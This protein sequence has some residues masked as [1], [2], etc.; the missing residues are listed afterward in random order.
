M[1]EFHTG[2]SSSHLPTGACELLAL[3]DRKFSFAHRYPAT[4]SAN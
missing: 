2:M 4:I 3:L 1:F